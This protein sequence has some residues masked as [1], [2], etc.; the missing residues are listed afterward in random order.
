MNLDG[1]RPFLLS[2]ILSLQ[3]KNNTTAGIRLASTETHGFHNHK[4]FRYG[5]PSLPP[6][7]T[8][9]FPLE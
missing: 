3:L 1:F 9:A 2:L 6:H 8:Q 5:C 7:I 4:I